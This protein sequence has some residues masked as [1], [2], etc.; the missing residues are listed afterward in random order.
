MWHEFQDPIWVKT[1]LGEGVAI[2]IESSPHDNHWTVILQN[3]AIVTFRQSEVLSGNNYSA[4]IG[5]SHKQ[6]R[7]TLKKATKKVRPGG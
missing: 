5:L 2:L 6:M 4:G 1:P 3:K 7:K